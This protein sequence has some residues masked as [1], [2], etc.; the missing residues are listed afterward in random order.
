MA[1]EEKGEVEKFEFDSAGH[2]SLDRAR[3]LALQHA[4]DNLHFYGQCS[5]GEAVW[6]V[7]E[8][9]ETDDYYEIKLSFRPARNFRGVAGVE[10]VTIDREGSIESRQILSEPRPSRRFV[11]GLLLSGILLAAGL[12]TIGGLFALGVF[13]PPRAA[14]P[15]VMVITPNEA[16]RLVSAGGDVTIDVAAGTV[17]VPSQ[18][19]YRSLADAETPMLPQ[20]YRVTGK[21]FDLTV[22]AVLL[23]PIT[24]TVGISAAD[25]LLAEGKEANIAMQ[26]Y[27]QGAWTQMP[28]TVD[29]AASTAVG[30][31]ESLSFFA[32]TIKLGE[33]AATPAPTPA[34]IST[35]ISSGPVPAP[36]AT[37]TPP[38]PTS[39]PTATPALAPT[40]TPTPTPVPTPLLTP[41][42]VSTAN[43]APLQAPTPVLTPIPTPTPVPTPEP[44]ATPAPTPT[45]PPTPTPNPT[46]TPTPVAVPTPV[47]TPAPTPTTPPTP[48]PN[49]TPTPTR[50]RCQ[51]HAGPNAAANTNANADSNSYTGANANAGINAGAGA[52]AH[53]DSNSYTDANAHASINAGAGANAHAGINAGANA[54]SNTDANPNAGTHG[55]SDARP[56]SSGGQNHLPVR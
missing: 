55:D 35:P 50:W 20:Q 2:M 12:A 45:T 43:A 27:R 34:V 38:T 46:P 28:T 47:P 41:T 26:H 19:P 53:A 33:P 4:R 25:A 9:Q 22:E 36:T 3:V 1:E 39:S 6:A 24:I 7:L 51:R 13:S 48:T 14:S 44:T 10:L 17:D 49:P 30:R 21:A 8:A 54:D 31:V 18:L 37:T 11:I 42:P 16:T 40:P 56:A 52:N 29:F 32:L 5:G 15:I 23:K